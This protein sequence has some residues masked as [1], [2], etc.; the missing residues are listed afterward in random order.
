MHKQAHVTEHTR[1]LMQLVRV[2]SSEVSLLQ[3]A[4]VAVA[5]GSLL[6]VA[7]GRRLGRRFYG[8]IGR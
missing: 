4:V 5:V 8:R 3:E 1:T 7:S 6:L 2:V